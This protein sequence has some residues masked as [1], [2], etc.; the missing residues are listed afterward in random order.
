VLYGAYT[1]PSGVSVN[2][3]SWS[4]DGTIVAG[5]TA[6]SS[7]GS[8]NTNVTLNQQ[9]TT[10]Y[11]VV[12][13]NSLVVTLTLNLSN[14]A[15]VSAS[16]TF[17][18]GAPSPSAPTVTLPTNGKL[19]IDTLTGCA[20]YP[21]DSAMVFGNISGPV[22]NCPGPYTGTPGIQF[23]PPTT[24]SPPGTFFFVQLVDSDTVYYSS[25]TCAAT[26]TPGLDGQYP[27]QGKTGQSVNDAPFIQLP[28]TYTTASRNFSATMYLMWQ[29]GSANS[30]PVPMGS[31]AWTISASTSQS[32]GTWSTPS[33]SG[34][35][36]SFTPASKTSD[37]P[38]WTGTVGNAAN[39][40]H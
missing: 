27:Y 10:F 9:Q 33:G 26:N 22:P 14:G 29:S 32:N 24:S 13:A 17:N 6:S 30:I 8:V 20:G 11:W 34:S 21:S 23:S 16:A 4:V 12:P 1:L 37:F 35:A 2:S 19:Y 18:V 40:C 3:K 39:N 15:T 5:Y 7:S 36:S 31:V 38:H 28:A 25:L